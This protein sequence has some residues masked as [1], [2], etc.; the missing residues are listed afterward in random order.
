MKPIV[1]DQSLIAYCGLYCGA[2]KKYISGTCLG[3]HENNKA[4]WCKVRACNIQN[5]YQSCA[6][7]KEFSNPMD[8]KK[9][10]NFFSK[11]FALVFKSDR[12]ACIDKIK[13]EGYNGFALYMAE[14]KLQSI[15]RI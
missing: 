3:C 9:F 1:V 11:F 5:N 10:N 12:A 6:D 14:H 15:K 8:C 13:K 7:C 4:G 2:C